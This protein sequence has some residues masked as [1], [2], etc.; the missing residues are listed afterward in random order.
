MGF[1]VIV[2]AENV[3]DVANRLTTQTTGV[4][5]NLALLAAIAVVVFTY[6]KTRAWVPTLV[7]IVMAGV[8]VWAVNS[9]DFLRG[10]TDRT[11]REAGQADVRP[12]VVA[13][14]SQHWVQPSAVRRVA[15]HP[16]R[17]R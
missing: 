3:I 15:D 7:A 16:H 5:R 10:S 13:D 8:V 6:F 9:T 1:H 11:I 2:L 4:L 14:A 12:L 17:D